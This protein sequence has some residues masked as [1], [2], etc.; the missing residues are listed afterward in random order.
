MA[1]PRERD[2]S[3]K[4]KLMHYPH[5]MSLPFGSWKK[6]RNV[7]L[8][9]KAPIAHNTASF[10]SRDLQQQAV[11]HAQLQTTQ[12]GRIRCIVSSCSVLLVAPLWPEWAILSKHAL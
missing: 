9:G 3:K 12:P 10:A 7:E 4:P 1:A 11:G 6:E 5:T 8:D 2:L